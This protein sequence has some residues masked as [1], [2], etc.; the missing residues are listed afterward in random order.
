M[1]VWQS[2]DMPRS[3]NVVFSG[4]LQKRQAKLRALIA[5]DACVPAGADE[6]ESIVIVFLCR[7]PRLTGRLNELRTAHAPGDSNAGRGLPS[8]RAGTAFDSSQEITRGRNKHAARSMS[9]SARET[10]PKIPH[11]G[12]VMLDTFVREIRRRHREASV[13]L[14]VEVEPVKNE[15]EK[16]LPVTRFLVIHEDDQHIAPAARSANVP[17][18]GTHIDKLAALH[19]RRS[20]GGRPRT[21]KA[22]DVDQGQRGHE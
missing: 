3:T 4:V 2:G 8:H 20:G 22:V 9:G 1:W 19:M 17:C 13:C 14:P 18:L 12:Y 11:I 21:G 5:A 6:I 15:V 7:N 16:R 10:L